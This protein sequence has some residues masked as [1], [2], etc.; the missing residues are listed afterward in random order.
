MVLIDFPANGPLW[1]GFNVKTLVGWYSNIPVLSNLEGEQERS[2]QFR[3]IIGLIIN[4][5]EILFEGRCTGII[6]NKKVRI[7]DIEKAFIHILKKYKYDW[8]GLWSIIEIM[9]NGK[10]KYIGLFDLDDWLLEIN[11]VVDI[12]KF[13]GG[14]I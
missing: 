6:I 9:K 1:F 3:T 5:K 8:D 2:A 11:Y 7:N 13:V 12:N 14:S 4:G 10:I